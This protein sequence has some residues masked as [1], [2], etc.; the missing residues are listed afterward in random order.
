M[1][2][3]D[4]QADLLT[5]WQSSLRISLQTSWLTHWLSDLLLHFKCS[6]QTFLHD[7]VS[8]PSYGV[9]ASAI[10]VSFPVS[11]TVCWLPF[12]V[13]AKLPVIHRHLGRAS[14]PMVVSRVTVHTYT[15]VHNSTTSDI[16]LSA[17][18]GLLP[19]LCYAMC[20]KCCTFYSVDITPAPSC[21]P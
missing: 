9:L 4:L 6:A 3:A 20:L 1:P 16:F 17:R 19:C 14:T 15:H 13:R 18:H 12:L 2:Q 10:F 5:S 8:G 7:L 11:L 21:A